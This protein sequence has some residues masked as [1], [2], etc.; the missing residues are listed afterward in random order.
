MSKSNCEK[1]DCE[2]YVELPSQEG[3]TY[4]LLT[5]PARCS[6]CQY[7]ERFDGYLKSTKKE[8]SC[9]E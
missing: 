3:K 5:P 7:Y 9:P 4:I 6:A 1:I 8:N 2:Y